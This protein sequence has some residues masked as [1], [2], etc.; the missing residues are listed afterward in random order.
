MTGHLPETE[1]D[2]LSNLRRHRRNS[3][4]QGLSLPTLITSLGVKDES[5]DNRRMEDLQAR[6]KA[7]HAALGKLDAICQYENVPRSNRES[8]PELYKQRVRRYEAGLEPD[9]SPKSTLKAPP[10]GAAGGGSS[11]PRNAKRSYPCATLERSTP[12]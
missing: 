10:P 8:L 4:L 11:S 6:L 5:H 1:F 2:P 3:I 7:T 12:R 9:A